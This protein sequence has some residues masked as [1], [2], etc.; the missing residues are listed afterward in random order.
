M[1]AAVQDRSIDVHQ[2]WA[3]LGVSTVYEAAGQRGLVEADLVQVVP[4]SRV[5]GPAR[6]V[7]C[8]QDDNLAV[9]LAMEGLRPG[10]IL[11]VTMP[12]PRP[13]ALVG[14]LLALQAQAH[15]AAGLLVDAAV[16]DREQ[17]VTLGI[18]AWARW[19]RAAGTTKA[20]RGELDIRVTVGGAAI[21]PGDIVVLDAD[22]AVVVARARAAEVL[23]A[24]EARQAK[25]EAMLPRL[26]AGE[27][28]AD[29]NGLRP[30]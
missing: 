1:L 5:A 15:G 19:I 21:D 17:L 10:D 11:V 13:V 24:S 23:E 26:R 12:E 8:G 2:R 16:R 7:R 27:L 9:H 6:T 22:G 3:E 14:E 18:P 30:L 28:T 20:D 4:G 29:L 25:E